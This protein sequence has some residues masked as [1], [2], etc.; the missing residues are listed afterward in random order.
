MGAEAS[1]TVMMCHMSTVWLGCSDRAGV[2][3]MAGAAVMVCV[4]TVVAAFVFV[5]QVTSG[6]VTVNV[7]VIGG[8]GV[9]SAIASSKSRDA[10]SHFTQKC[11]TRAIDGT[12]CSYQA[13]ASK[14][15]WQFR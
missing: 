3:K 11:K 1:L 2:S 9:G 10:R 15:D 5:K 13:S 12:R 8:T 4:G 7:A 6:S 14:P